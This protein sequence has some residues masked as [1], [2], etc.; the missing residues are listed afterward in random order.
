MWEGHTVSLQPD[1]E[2]SRMLYF[3]V[4]GVDLQRVTLRVDDQEPIIED[5]P[6]V[7][8]SGEIAMVRWAQEYSLRVTAEDRHGTVVS[9]AISVSGEE[10]RVDGHAEETPFRVRMLRMGPTE[11]VDIRG[12][13]YRGRMYRHPWPTCTT[14]CDLTR[15][16]GSLVAM[17]TGPTDTLLLL[18]EGRFP[19]IASGL[20]GQPHPDYIIV[21]I[22]V[23]NENSL[24]LAAVT[25][26]GDMLSGRWSRPPS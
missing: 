20:G 25:G 4:E 1:P 2:R 12:I 13:G 23:R 21:S 5:R 15:P 17:V 22:P 18:F 6:G 10:A 19:Y 16:G 26:K 7:Y 8:I 14:G 3:F 24:E 9:S 11:G